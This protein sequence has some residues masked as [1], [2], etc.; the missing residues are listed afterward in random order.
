MGSVFY[1]VSCLGSEN[2]GVLSQFYFLRWIVVH[3]D[4]VFAKKKLRAKL[5]C[6]HLEKGS[7][8]HPQTPQ[9]IEK[10]VEQ[11]EKKTKIK[12]KKYIK[13]TKTQKKLG[14]TTPDPKNKSCW[15]L[16]SES[17]PESASCSRPN[18]PRLHP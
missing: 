17:R 9:T 18:R 13:K 14:A 5:R 15:P 3:L 2:A 16:R 1:C 12:R 8:S 6:C 7:R 4:E 10:C 11:Q